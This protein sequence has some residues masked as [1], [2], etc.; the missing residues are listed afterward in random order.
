MR[1]HRSK[2]LALV[3]AMTMVLLCTE[4][5]RAQPCDPSVCGQWGSVKPMK[6]TDPQPGE[7]TGRM[8]AVHSILLHTGKVLCIDQHRFSEN[9][10]H[11]VLFEPAEDPNDE[12]ITLV[13]D[14]FAINGHNLFCS[15]HAALADGRI[16][17]SGGGGQPGVFQT[18]V[19]TPST[20]P[21]DSPPQKCV[22]AGIRL[23]GRIRSSAALTGAVNSRAESK[24]TETGSVGA[25]GPSVS[26]KRRAGR[27]PSPWTCRSRSAFA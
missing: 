16:F 14:S 27:R 6:L 19:Y 3:I 18:T 20:A 15:G 1:T 8:K 21:P 22:L 23:R 13:S 24:S 10:P 2:L 11:I 25:A 17:F 7:P 5:L 26:A 12:T 9:T 4:T